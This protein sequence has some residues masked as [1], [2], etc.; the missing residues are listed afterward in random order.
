MRTLFICYLALVILAFAS[1]QKS[2]Q[3]A[4]VP[5]MTTDCVNNPSACNSGLYQQSP[6]FTPYNYN[7]NTPYGGGYYGGNYGYTYGGYA[8]GTYN[9]FVFGNNSAYLCNCPVGSVPTY[10]NYAGLGCVQSSQFYGFA[11]VSFGYG[12]NNNQWTN[13]PQIS[14]QVGYGNSSCYNG[15]VQSCLVNNSSTCSVGYSCRSNSASSSL[16]ICVSN[17]SNPYFGQVLR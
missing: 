13:I 1:C 16:G 3:E 12:A 7:G 10:N 5:T 14:N 11:Y 17:N 9:P 15:V 4:V 6:G 2:N 8:G